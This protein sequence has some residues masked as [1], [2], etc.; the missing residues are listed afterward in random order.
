LNCVNFAWLASSFRAR[1]AAVSNA[2]PGPLEA[3][4][5]LC[6]GWG[7]RT[8]LSLPVL[9]VKVWPAPEL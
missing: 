3:G 9:E 8:L 7:S 2:R 6:A 4:L 5:A 1:A